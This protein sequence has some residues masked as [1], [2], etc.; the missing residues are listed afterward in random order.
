MKT[1]STI[2]LAMLVAVLALGAVGCKSDTTATG[3][4]KTTTPGM[5]ATLTPPP[6]DAYAGWTKVYSGNFAGGKAPEWA[7]LSGKVEV[8]DGKLAF[9][10]AE[11][12]ETQ[13][14]LKDPKCPGS[15]MIDCMA[16]VTGATVSDISP[17]LN[18]SDG[19]YQNGYM[20]QFGGKANTVNHLLK[21]GEVVPSTDKDKPLLQAGK[22]YHVVACN[23]AGKITLTVDGAEIFSFVDKTPLNG[24]GH[25]QVGFYT[26]QTTL[27]LD[28][29]AVYVKTSEMTPAPAK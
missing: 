28:K 15:V 29:V 13:V 26:Y 11:E 16:T 19:G 8:A 3:A 6:A 1:A 27:K 25:N 22:T 2:G 5:G 17:I 10:P 7:A 4:E 20:L 14:V 12:G 23:D 9:L 24:A 18:G 21:E